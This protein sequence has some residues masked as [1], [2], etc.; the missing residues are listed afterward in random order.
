[1]A[2][3]NSTANLVKTSM[4]LTC[5]CKCLSIR[6]I[7]ISVVQNKNSQYFKMAD[8]DNDSQPF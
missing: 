7:L 3:I 5:I 6:E 2:D 4:I 1:M 8:F